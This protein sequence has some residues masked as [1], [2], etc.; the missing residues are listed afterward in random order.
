MTEL[1]LLHD[2]A[3][4]LDTIVCFIALLT[5]FLLCFVIYQIF[6]HLFKFWLI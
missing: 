4:S 2:I 5:V 1:E 6:N 3:I